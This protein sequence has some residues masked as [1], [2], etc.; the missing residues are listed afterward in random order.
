MKT[1][2][3]LTNSELQKQHQYRTAR[4]SQTYDDIWKSVGK[5]VFCDLKDKYILFEENDVVM[6][7]S[8]FAYIDGHFMIIPRQHVQSPKDLSAVQW[9]TIRKFTYLAKKMIKKVTNVKSMQLVYKDGENAQ[10]TVNDHMH[11]HCIPFDAPDLSVWNFRNLEYTPL[12]NVDR[13]KKVAKDI[14]SNSIKFEE[15]YRNHSTLPIICDVLIRNQKG[16]FL[17]QERHEEFKFHPDILTIP[18]GHVDNFDN[19]LEE[20]LAREVLEEVCISINPEQL[21]LIASR[22]QSLKSIRTSW[23]LKIK[24]PF[25]HQFL[26]NTY[27]LSETVQEN[28]CKPGDDAKELVWLSREEIIEHPKVSDELKEIFQNLRD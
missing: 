18:G 19:S 11:I 13:Y 1:A 5:C 6:T 12:E 17:F 20:E 21:K 14:I 8:L 27:L 2:T 16:E 3:P 7:I 26:W 28:L 25:K 22:I 4:T 24:Y 10:G 15:K 23:H 9:E